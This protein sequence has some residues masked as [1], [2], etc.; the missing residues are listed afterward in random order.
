MKVLRMT[1]VK[2]LCV[3]GTYEKWQVFFCDKLRLKATFYTTV[4]KSVMSYGNK[5][6]WNR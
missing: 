4:L 1:P 3:N 5:I 6:K 2:E